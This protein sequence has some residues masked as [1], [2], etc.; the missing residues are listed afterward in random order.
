MD[1][2]GEVENAEAGILASEQNRRMKDGN[3]EGKVPHALV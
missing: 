1:W 2:V 3:A